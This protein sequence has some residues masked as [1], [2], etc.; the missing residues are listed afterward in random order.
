MERLAA[1][2]S[3]SARRPAHKPLVVQ[4]FQSRR[5]NRSSCS[6]NPQSLVS[7][8]FASAAQPRREWF[9]AKCRNFPHYRVGFLDGTRGKYATLQQVRRAAGGS[10]AWCAT[11]MS[12]RRVE[13]QSF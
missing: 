10:A 12:F 7:L 13:R 9:D 3:G 11:T 5:K 6:T 1:P 2:F 8:R 4:H